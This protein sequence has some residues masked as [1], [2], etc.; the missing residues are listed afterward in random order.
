MRAKL[1][2]FVAALVLVVGAAVAGAVYVNHRSAAPEPGA[3]V[4]ADEFDGSAGSA[5]D[6][7]RWRH[8][9]GGSGWGNEELQYYTDGSANAALDG[10]GHLVITARPEAPAGSSCWYGTCRYSSARLLT[11]GAFSHQ[12]GRFE[13][14]MKVPAGTGTWP[15]FWMLGDN[16]AVNPWPA[17]GE[18]DVMEH[19]GTEPAVVKGSM[20]GP[21]F[22]ATD[23][24][25]R[26]VRLRGGGD[27]ADDFHTFAVDW[28]PDSVTWYLD[29]RRYSQFTRDD[30]PQGGW[31]FDRP[32]FLLVNLA[33]GG[34]W[35]GEPDPSTPFPAELVVDYVRVYELP[36]VQSV[37]GAPPV[38]PGGAPGPGDSGRVVGY[39]GKCLDVEGGSAVAGAALH[40]W[41]CHD[42]VATQT[43]TVGD[44]G[45][46]RN[47]GLCM[48]VP[49]G[50]TDG[51]GLVLEVCDNRATQKFAVN[52]AGDLSLS[53]TPRC[54]DV[55][56]WSTQ[57]GTAVQLWECAGSPNQKWVFRA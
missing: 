53:G 32:F 8:D 14:R 33:I 24:L 47:G 55:S 44:D 26:D 23:S 21:G 7:S 45:T 43:W 19:V 52:D 56:G 18:I 37:S 41:D 34:I 28:T 11:A 51:V 39:A 57:N 15:A 42:G 9:V 13:A 54:G 49:D 3:V 35:P 16:I 31:V 48:S 30:V 29:G 17:S 46:L 36:G 1:P 20:H 6:P 5:A 40:M 2:A 10:S 4:W 27:F 25:N 50:S 12:Y 22:S 38:T